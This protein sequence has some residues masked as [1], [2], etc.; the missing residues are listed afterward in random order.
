METPAK[1]IEAGLYE[2]RGY[3]IEN[4]KDRAD[5]RYTL[6][7][8]TKIPAGG[9]VYDAYE[10]EDAAN[11]LNEAKWFIDNIYLKEDK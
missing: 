7:N 11:T 1:K 2:Y 8:I 9:D 6:W 3:A 4:M 10:A 5:A